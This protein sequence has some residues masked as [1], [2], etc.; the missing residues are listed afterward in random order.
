LRVVDV[1]EIC[2][3]E[4]ADGIHLAY[5]VVGDG[6][7]T[8]VFMRLGNTLIDLLWQEPGFVRTARRL[9]G[10]ARTVWYD[11]RG[12]GASGGE[13]GDR[14]VEEIADADLGAVLDAVGC[15]QVVLVE[16]GL[17]QAGDAIRYATNH[18]ERVR[19]LI[20]INTCAHYVREDDYPWGIPKEDLDRYFNAAKAKWGTGSSVAVI[21]PSKANDPT[22]REWWARGERL[23]V[24]VDEGAA[25]LRAAF[26][27]DV[28]SLLPTINIPTL[29][30]HRAGTRMIRVGAGRYL[31]EHIPGAKYVELPG[32]D[33]PYYVG[34]TDALCDEIEEFLT[35]TRTA[36]EGDVVT[37]TVLF[38]DIVASTEQAARLGHRKWEALH[39]THDTTVRACLGR[40][41]GREIK[42]IG[43]GFLATF[44][45]TS[46]AVR[47]AIDI[48]TQAKHIG[49]DV[50]AGIHTGE[51]EVR[52]NDVVGLPVAITKRICDLAQPGEVLVSETVPRLVTGSGIEFNDRG[53]HELK[54][55]P[56]TW[57]LF[58]V[59]N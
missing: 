35:G 10:F 14:L 42:T 31:A 11:N 6:P 45:A 39:E 56:G 48:V 22:F 20:L 38:T 2:F 44:D 30:L 18:P 4:T 28:R 52:P 33:H 47:A 32:E 19:A 50:R 29:V 40:Y 58:A 53:E 8:L 27:Q 26:E 34:D 59:A 9:A 36:P 54:G 49:L 23:G 17:G 5:Q 57:K 21:A 7:V 15:E 12:V 25:N 37:A 43:D 13:F 16:A 55:V 1:P 46:R 3:A 41:R 24:G 51:V